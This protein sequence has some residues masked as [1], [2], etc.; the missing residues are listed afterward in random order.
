[1]VEFADGNVEWRFQD[2]PAAEHWTIP[3]SCSSGPELTIVASDPSD[4]ISWE[5][6]SARIFWRAGGASSSRTARL[7]ASGIGRLRGIPPGGI[8]V[9]LYDGQGRIVGSARGRQLP[10]GGTIEVIAGDT[11]TT[12]HVV[13]PEGNPVSD[14]EVHVYGPGGESGWFE[15]GKTDSSGYWT[16]P[17][18]PFESALCGA[19]QSRFGMV[20]GMP[21]ERGSL[22]NIVLDAELEV[23]LRLL[24]GAEP[25]SGIQVRLLGAQ[26]TYLIGHAASDGQGEVHFPFLGEGSYHLFVD[27]PGYLPADY[28]IEA[29][30]LAEPTPFQVYE[31]GD[32]DVEVRK[33]GG[34]PVQG[35]H[36]EFR[37]EELG[38]SVSV[39]EE[40][41]LVEATPAGLI[42]DASGKLYVK[43]VPR[44]AYHW[45]LVEGSDA[46]LAGVVVVRSKNA[47]KL[48]IVLP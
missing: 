46:P 2:L 33:L 12:F 6:A 16:C 13:D 41:S 18:I 28:L 47:A 4:E 27:H 37:H 15:Y 31:L 40:T 36:L 35:A 17:S 34:A 29:A 3:V 20:F 30:T 22:V 1:M 8:G 48:E 7:D 39:W 43:G 10:Q 24:Q 19:V 14:A 9:T 32:I 26:D 23:A 45:T 5:N 11:S 38:V 21:V 25:Q 44:G 42:T